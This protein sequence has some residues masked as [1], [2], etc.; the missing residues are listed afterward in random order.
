[1]KGTFYNVVFT[2][3]SLYMDRNPLDNY[4]LRVCN[5]RIMEYGSWM[6][7]KDDGPTPYVKVTGWKAT[8][9]VSVNISNVLYCLPCEGEVVA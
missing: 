6:V 1:M 3:M 9:V 8:D 2:N 4:G 5:G 7:K